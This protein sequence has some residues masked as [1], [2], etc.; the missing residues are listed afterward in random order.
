MKKRVLSLILTLAMA[1]SLAV[2]ALALEP[3]AESETLGGTA[4]LME[5]Y[6]FT[7]QYLADHPEIYES[8]DPDA[9]Y[10]TQYYGCSKE[11]Y[12]AD[13]G[14]TTQEEFKA[15]MWVNAR[16]YGSEVS[17]AIDNAYSN[18]VISVFEASHPGELDTVDV[19]TLLAA[20]GYEDMTAI[21]RYMEDNGILSQETARSGILSSYVWD[22]LAAEAQHTSAQAYRTAQPETWESFDAD[23]YFAENYLWYDSREKFMA[24]YCLKSEEEFREHM[25]VTYM[26]ELAQPVYDYDDDWQYSYDEEPVPLRLVVNGETME[27]AL[28]SAEDG[29]SYIAPATVNAILG[30]HYVDEGELLPLRATME[31]EGW[32]V[33]WNERENAIFLIDRAAVQTR[34]EESIAALDAVMGWAL[35]HMDVERGQSYRTTETCEIKITTLNSLDGDKD[36]TLRLTLDMLQKDGALELT[37]KLNAADVLKLLGDD[38]VELAVNEIPQL[39][40]KD[41]PALL[42]GLEFKAIADL[43]NGNFYWNLPLLAVFD[44]TVTAGTWYGASLGMGLEEMLQASL[45]MSFEELLG[46]LSGILGQFLYEDLLNSSMRRWSSPEMAWASFEEMTAVF[47]AI[48]GAGCIDENNGTLTWKVDTETVNGLMARMS[49]EDIAPFKAY[50]L[51]YVMRPNG[52]FTADV[53]MR[54][55]FAALARAM[56]SDSYY[57]GSSVY[58]LIS[59]FT[60]RF[61]GLFDFQIT[62]HS[63]G[64]MDHAKGEMEYHQKNAFKVNM[65][66]EAQRVKTNTAP[67]LTPPEGAPVEMVMDLGTALLFTPAL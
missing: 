42:K 4:E 38:L 36:Y 22:R 12:M 66:T 2:P 26:D 62:A 45:G 10:L 25:Y 39:S 46:G 7:E 33:G 43:D 50:E 41:L 44:D 54:P 59:I 56:Y 24:V 47:N 19:N 40:M 6:T 3:P 23:A 27:D 32:D 30:S 35:E 49:G 37:V 65:T 1:L 15:D 5:Y 60:G 21:E 53:T 52:T 17:D 13:M 16:W 8:F 29:W 63:S 51:S 61:L 9:Y 58:S 31:A 55:D 48:M 34:I 14:L 28:V 57:Y 64:S 67:A 18:Y 20:W 11:D